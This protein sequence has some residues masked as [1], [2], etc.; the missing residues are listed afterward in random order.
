MS[1]YPTCPIPV[2]APAPAPRLRTGRWPFSRLTQL[3]KASGY[4]T[5]DLSHTFDRHEPP[6]S[7][8]ERPSL[9]L[10]GPGEGGPGEPGRPQLMPWRFL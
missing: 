2:S 7:P 6:A 3:L 5:V 4:A 10:A 1:D 9:P 8:P